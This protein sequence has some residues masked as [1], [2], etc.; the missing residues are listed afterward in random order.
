M[1]LYVQ[2]YGGS[3]VANA[4]CMRRV[5][6][7]IRDTQ[8]AGNRV[9]VV[10]SAMGDTTDDLIA[11]AK[12]VNPEPNEREMDSL[13][14]T[15]EM[16]SSAILTMALHALGVQA[17]S[18]TGQQAGIK[19]DGT[20]LKAKIQEINPK[21]IKQHLDL[22]Y[23]VVVAGFQGMNPAEDIATLGRGGSDTTAVALAAALK[24]DR[25]QILKDVDGVFTANPR[26]VPAARKLDAIAYEEMLELASCGAEVLQSRAVEFAKNYG[27][28]LEVM[29]SFEVKPGTLVREEDEEMEQMII[30]GIAADKNQAK[31]TLLGVPDTPGVAAR[32]FK[33][34][35]GANLNVDMIVQN[36]SAAGVTDVSFTVAKDD[37]SKT[38]RVIEPLVAEIKAAGL[39]FDPD[40]AKVSIVG[41]G[42]KSHSG[43]AYQMFEVL[44]AHRI[45][46]EMIST[47][48][49]KISVAIRA[50]DAD[51]AVRALH[52]AFGLAQAAPQAAK[53]KT[54]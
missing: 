44:A 1:A 33:A 28:V 41:V 9:V 30:R 32:I 16:A 2:K 20:H 45:N 54:K 22:G 38:R 26:V 6:Q 27:V 37:I 23:V 18:M 17:I 29:S 34:L 46:I 19:V 49:I 36:V 13:M 39:N 42:M 50:Q 43:V 4:E 5:A 21:R 35:A 48:E 24:A 7:R 12:Q 53:R 11:L 40:I 52:E 15:G 51:A 3:S 31:A 8:A 47:S 14:A 25:C 10:V